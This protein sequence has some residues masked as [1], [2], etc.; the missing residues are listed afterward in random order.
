MCVC[1]C[2]CVHVTHIYTQYYCL[3]CDTDIFVVEYDSQGIPVAEMNE[4]VISVVAVL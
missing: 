1:V 4:S 3:L 2:V